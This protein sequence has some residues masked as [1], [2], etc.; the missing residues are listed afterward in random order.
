MGLPSSQQEERTMRGVWIGLTVLAVA[1]AARAGVYNFAED[2][3]AV[4]SYTARDEVLKVRS[5]GVD[6]GEPKPFKTQILHVKDALEEAKQD[7]LLSTLDRVTLSGCYLR[8]RKYQEAAG[9][10]RR[11]DQDHFLILA[12]LAAAHFLLED[13]DQAVHFQQRAL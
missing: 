1:P 7:G 3:S 10:L 11:G 4:N 8:L 9:L 2:A 6:V 13:F 5:A 12:N